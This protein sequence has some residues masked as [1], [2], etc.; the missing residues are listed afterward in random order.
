M[1][2]PYNNI[3]IFNDDKWIPS[4]FL[5]KYLLIIIISLYF[6]QIKMLKMLIFS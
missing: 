1:D 2:Y 4:N 3:Y 6:S 5:F